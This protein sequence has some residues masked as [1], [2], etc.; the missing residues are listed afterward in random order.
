MKGIKKMRTV[1]LAEKPSQAKAYASAFSIGRKDKSF[2]EIKPCSTFPSGAIITWGIGHLVSLK[3]PGDYRPEWKKWKLQNLPI[4]PDVFEF[5]VSEGK[6]AQFNIVKRLFQ[7]A[8][9]LINAC[10]IDR[11]GSNIFYS[12]YNMTGVGQKEIKRLWINS[13]EVDEIKKGFSHLQSNEKDLLMYSE[14]KARQLSDWLVGMNASQLYTLL[15]K[16]KGVDTTLSVGRVQSPTVFMIYQ[17]QKEIENFVSK[18]FYE[19][20]GTFEGINGDY[21]GKAKIKKDSLE[22]MA[23]FLDENKLILKQPMSGIITSLEKKEKRLKSPRLHSLSTLQVTANKRWKYSPSK[24][25]E[26]MQSL[27]EKKLV[28]YPRTDT[29]HITESE[30]NYLKQAVMDYQKL[31]GVNFEPNLRPNKRYVDASKVQEHYA[32]IPTKRPASEKVF[33]GLRM[34]EKNIYEEIVRNTLAMFHRDYRYEETKIVTKVN[35]VVFESVGRVETDKG[36]KELFSFKASKKDEEQKTLP[37]VTKGEAVQAVLAEKEGQ[38]KPPKPF[39]EGDLI[40][41]M[42]TAGKMVED[43]QE[44]E[45]LKEVEGIGTEATRASIIET[46]KKNGY[47]EVTKNTTT[48]TNKGIVLC[49]SIEGT[50]LSS[51]AMTAKWEKYLKKIGNGEGSP[52][53]FLASIVKFIQHLLVTAPEQMAHATIQTIE[54]DSKPSFTPGKGAPV[55]GTCPVCQKGTVLDMKT[56]AGCSEYRSGCKFSVSRTIAKKKLSDAQ[57]KR[58]IEKGKT[59]VIKGFK[60]KAGNPFDAQ[61]VIENGEVKFEFSP[62][63]EQQKT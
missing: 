11:E 61:L 14:A 60:S 4:V 8:D 9:V 40:N 30:F 19:L 51:P 27:Y 2:I 12:I 16:E 41:M 58:L 29:N 39:T 38:T 37:I 31:I 59:N 23:A 34:E 6:Q 32:I 33:Q 54:S 49:E 10:D 22:E 1:I 44:S 21:V 28:T 46:I 45:I 25:L 50:L 18:T 3:M 43:D 42:K 20:A 15:L 13:L 47:I 5:M 53:A 7:E 48:V 62:S 35:E 36:W 56:F 63:Q 55:L 26:T 24:V 17:R 52:D 57:I